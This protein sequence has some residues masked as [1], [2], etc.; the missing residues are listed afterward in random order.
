MP[1]WMPSSENALE[2]AA[3]EGLDEERYQQFLEEG[4]TREAIE[5]DTPNEDPLSDASLLAI[6]EDVKR[7]SRDW[8]E[9]SVRNRVTQNYDL[10][11][12]YH[13]RG[14]KYHS[15][16]YEKRSKIFRPKVRAN[17]NK[18]TAA[19]ATAFFSTSDVVNCEAE[20]SADPKQRLAAA[21]NMALLN[22][23]LE[24]TIP[25]YK[26]V[27]AAFQEAVVTG[28]V[29]S[30]Q[31][32]KYREKNYDTE[33]TRSDENGN[34]MV[35]DQ[36]E[37]REVREDTPWVRLVPI[38]NFGIDPSC[39][40][41]DP[42]NS[43]PY[44]VEYIPTYV[45]DIMERV[46]D[47]NQLP[48]YR[49]LSK[50][51]IRSAMQEDYDAVRRAREGHDRQD[52]YED[53]QHR[54]S[55]FDTVWIHHHIVEID[56]QDYVFDTLGT[57]MMLS[58]PI[59]AEDV[60]PTKGRPYV[61]GTAQIEAH[62]HYPN[63]PTDN[64][65]PLQE[66]VN[67]LANLRLDNVKLALNKRYFVRRGQVSDVRALIRNTPGGLV[68]MNDPER[69]VKVHETREVTQSS[70]EEHDR[71]NT[72]IDELTGAFTQTSV[73]SNR[74]MN[75]TVGGMNLLSEGTSQ[76]S[77]L[78]VRTFAET[79]MEPA[80]RQ[81]MD[82][83][84][85]LE[86]DETIMALVGDVV[87]EQEQQKRQTQ[88]QQEMPPAP[89]GQ[90]PPQPPQGPGQ[91]QQGQGQGQGAPK[92]DEMPQ[93]QQAPPQPKP[94]I[95]MQQVL[96]A[97]ETPVKVRVSVGFGATNPVKRVEKLSLGL[98]TMANYFPQ[99]MMAADQQEIAKELFG[100]L[101]YQDGSRF[102][103][104][105]GQQ[106]PQV[107]QLQQKLQELQQK[108]ETDQVKAQAQE[109]LEQIKQQGKMQIEE[110]KLRAKQSID[111]ARLS[112]D[113]FKAQ[114]E[115]EIK[116]LDA[117]RDQEENEIKKRELWM[118]REALSHSISM[119]E[120]EFALQ[121]QTM[122]QA[123]PPRPEVEGDP[124]QQKLAEDL[125][126]PPSGT[127]YPESRDEGAVDLAGED[128]AGTLSRDEYGKIPFSGQ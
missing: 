53:N 96:E 4:G 103:P 84:Q 22:Y 124:S 23:R 67:D 125:R 58:D 101:G 24:T 93:Q 37:E 8:F 85:A 11:N 114:V 33:V 107:M 32:W 12:S 97:L 102:F 111:E 99:S 70:Y 120:R 13:P 52:R 73:M 80:L 40:W 57:T 65:R 35:F 46:N 26:T 60:Y 9:T 28:V 7:H 68:Y 92:P 128:K 100:A 72:E 87:A 39:D 30:K 42:V 14:S 86:S 122:Q 90:E 91:G 47:P 82:Y 18:L 43:S 77:E 25:W 119:A 71:L 38:E 61:M 118:Q 74:K 105:I 126:E 78:T 41:M 10:F 51:E 112:L 98:Q 36:F 55:E 83:E 27:V 115:A 15:K 79:W 123:E 3:M 104:N 66:E 69:D 75:E 59:P 117:Q 44:V 121:V 56:G 20:N 34:P 5:E 16:W 113:Q 49:E 1:A 19:A 48:A 64:M 21:I 108:I 106:D 127:P 2:D 31:E 89:P 54:M 62:K 17:A 81:L 50:D 76:V 95:G 29:V 6:A 116:Q 109:R 88:A 63:S 45:G 94:Q 110:M